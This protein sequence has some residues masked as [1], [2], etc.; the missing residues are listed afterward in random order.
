M[1]N[2]CSISE[3]W[4]WSGAPPGIIAIIVLISGVTITSYGSFAC[5]AKRRRHLLHQTHP[6]HPLFHR[7]INGLHILHPIRYRT[8][9]H[10]TNIQMSSTS[11]LSLRWTKRWTPGHMR[12]RIE[13]SVRLF[14][15]MRLN[16]AAIMVKSALCVLQ[17][18]SDNFVACRCEEHRGGLE[19]SLVG[20]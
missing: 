20:E 5:T 3:R 16:V 15:G 8:A 18:A 10:A 9:V 1:E 2:I 7:S 14:I 13:S 19:A 17:S 12:Q 11:W 6:Q 4:T